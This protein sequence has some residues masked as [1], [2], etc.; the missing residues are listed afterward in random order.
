MK[1]VGHGQLFSVNA[2][3]QQPWMIVGRRKNSRHSHLRTNHEDASC[4]R[5]VE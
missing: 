2:V 3:N 5:T 4:P 1:D